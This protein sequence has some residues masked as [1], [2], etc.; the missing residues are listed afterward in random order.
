V[1]I[2][3]SG[4]LGHSNPTDRERDAQ[5]RNELQDLGYRVYEYTWGDLSCRP[6]YVVATLRQRVQ[7]GDSELGAELVGARRRGLAGVVLAD[8]R[9]AVPAIVPQR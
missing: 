1:V 7:V 2:E 8:V 9:E 6:D 4:R 3:V 5:R